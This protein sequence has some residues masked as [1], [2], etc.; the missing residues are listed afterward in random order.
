MSG[1]VAFICRACHGRIRSTRTVDLAT[2]IAH[3]Q[4]VCPDLARGA[5]R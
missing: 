3:H 2:A 5:R 1:T 4:A